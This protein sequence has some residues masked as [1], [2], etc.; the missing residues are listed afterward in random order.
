MR[1]RQPD[2][3]QIYLKLQENIPLTRKE[4]A[5][6]KRYWQKKKLAGTVI[7]QNIRSIDQRSQLSWEEF[8]E[9][10]KMRFPVAFSEQQKAAVHRLKPRSRKLLVVTSVILLLK[11]ACIIYF[12]W[13]LQPDSPAQPDWKSYQV[14]KG[15]QRAWMLP[16]G[17]KVWLNADTE[18]RCPETFGAAERVVE[19]KHGEAYFEVVKSATQPFIV[20]HQQQ[21]IQ[22]LGTHFNVRAYPNE[23]AIVTTLLEGSV[24]ITH[25]NHSKTLLPNQTCLNTQGELSIA[26]A[27]AAVAVAWKNNYFEFRDAPLSEIME[28]IGRCYNKKVVYKTPVPDVRFTIS[29]T[30][31][32]PV[33]ELLDALE[34][35]KLVHFTIRDNTIIV[36]Q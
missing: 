31:K 26:S 3:E 20:R 9:K 15:N 33:G 25:N 2:I 8:Q 29:G 32:E 16:D 34:A 21:T 13:T 22:V 10:N 12:I 19:L 7:D 11:A 4:Q 5:A 30:R 36:S 17:T 23:T 6:W 24:R 28:E 27:N 35:A 18:L 1:S 14:A